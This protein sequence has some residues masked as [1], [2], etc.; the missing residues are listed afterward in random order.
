M[1]TTQLPAGM[2]EGRIKWRTYALVAQLPLC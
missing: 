1:K 2:Q